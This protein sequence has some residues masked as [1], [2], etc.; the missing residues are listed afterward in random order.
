M[1]V[2]FS[3]KETSKILILSISA[4]QFHW[5]SVLSGY[6]RDTCKGCQVSRRDP[7]APGWPKDKFY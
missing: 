1:N 2:L 5:L 7:G 6:P 3:E 4:G